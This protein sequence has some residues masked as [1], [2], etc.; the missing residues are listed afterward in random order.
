MPSE[1][2]LRLTAFGEVSQEQLDQLRDELGL[3][4]AGRLTDSQDEQF[5]YRTERLGDT[6]VELTLSRSGA[7]AWSLWVSY[8]GGTPP[9][10]AWIDQYRSMFL[11]AIRNAGLRM[12]REWRTEGHGAGD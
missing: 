1:I 12:D 3:R 7:N 6:E 9:P 5:G 10:D 2:A 4:R 8:E 11:R